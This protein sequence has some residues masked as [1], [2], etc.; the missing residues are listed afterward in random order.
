MPR[1]YEDD[2]LDAELQD[3]WHAE[4]DDDD[5]NDDDWDDDDDGEG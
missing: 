5:W 2:D 3:D 1:W 4:D